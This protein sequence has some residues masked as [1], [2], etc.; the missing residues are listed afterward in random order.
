MT[1]EEYKQIEIEN[2]KEMQK[3]NPI[4]EEIDCEDYEVPEYIAKHIEKF[5]TP[6]D[7]DFKHICWDGNWESI[8]QAVLD[9]IKRGKAFVV[10]DWLMGKQE[11]ITIRDRQ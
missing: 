7:L 3:N 8:E 1:I 4:L 5:G 9:S 11:D 10:Y 2:C 6:P